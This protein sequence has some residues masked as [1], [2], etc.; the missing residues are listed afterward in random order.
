MKSLSSD[1][2][3]SKKNYVHLPL[4]MKKV[5][6][7][8]AFFYSLSILIR[9]PECNFQIDKQKNKLIITKRSAK[10]SFSVLFAATYTDI[11]ISSHC[12]WVV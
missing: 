10:Y 9:K 2:F 4:G 12:Y 3:N 7:T 8:V 1:W 6:S 5:M 11:N